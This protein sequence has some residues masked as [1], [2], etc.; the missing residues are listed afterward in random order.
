VDCVKEL[1]DHAADVTA[2]SRH[3]D[4]PLSLAARYGQLVC[5]RL[6]TYWRN[7]S[8]L[9]DVGLFLSYSSFCHSPQSYL[10]LLLSL[11]SLSFQRRRGP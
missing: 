2:L 4:T 8:L 3:G 7:T 1:V 9:V 5:V 6:L 11:L 10:E